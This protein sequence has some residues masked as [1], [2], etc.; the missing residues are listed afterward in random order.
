MHKRVHGH[1]LQ[2]IHVPDT[3]KL[4][5][6]STPSIMRKAH[7]WAGGAV[8]GERAWRWGSEATGITRPRRGHSRRE[9]CLS[10]LQ[11]RGSPVAG[12]P[13]RVRLS[14]LRRVPASREL[15]L[16]DEPGALPREYADGLRHGPGGLA[17][18]RAPLGHGV[19][20]ALRRVDEAG[21]RPEG[22]AN[23]LALPGRARRER[24]PLFPHAQVEE[25]LLLNP[26]ARWGNLAPG[27]FRSPRSRSQVTLRRQVRAAGEGFGVG[28]G[29]RFLRAL[30]KDFAG[31]AF[32]AIVHPLRLS[33][34]AQEG[35]ERAAGGF[36]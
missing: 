14:E 24:V 10:L 6:A 18:R 34:P 25:S 8:R 3:A 32:A 1:D 9:R 12:T 23:S 31:G 30:G 4:G 35:E 36:Q 15:L 11:N 22:A 21:G 28:T 33:T 7:G 16:G 26:G 13:G 2:K 27:K 20:R 17:D 29:H 19:G 5:S